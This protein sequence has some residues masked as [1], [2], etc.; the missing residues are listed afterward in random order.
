MKLPGQPSPRQ[1]ALALALVGTLLATWWA[2]RIEESGSLPV[3]AMRKK[4]PPPT[5]QTAPPFSP[6][7]AAGRPPWPPGGAELFAAPPNAAESPPVAVEP[8]APPL[9]FRY[10]GTLDEPGRAS[11]VVLLD[12]QDVVTVRAGERIGDQYLAARITPT[13]IE[14]IHLPT[15]QRQALEIADYD[16][17]K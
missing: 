12:G 11:T 5:G 16:M 3:P 6:P 15:R 1:A 17:R 4:M 9:P 13:R 7:L 8:T 14:F 2:S 10:L